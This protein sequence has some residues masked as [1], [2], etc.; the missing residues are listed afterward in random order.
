MFLYNRVN[1]AELKQKLSAESF[2]RLTISFYKYHMHESP[3]DFRDNLF[4]DWFPL[5]CFGRIYVAREGINAQMSI[6]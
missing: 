3:Q 6:P 1:K 2:Q 4:R 5:D